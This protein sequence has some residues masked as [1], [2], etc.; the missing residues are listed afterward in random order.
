MAKHVGMPSGCSIQSLKWIP[1][2]SNL[3]ASFANCASPFTS[4]TTY[5]LG[6][7]KPKIIMI[8]LE[9]KRSNLWN[10]F[11]CH[12]LV[13]CIAFDNRLNISLTHTFCKVIDNM[14]S[15]PSPENWRPRFLD[16]L[17]CDNGR[18]IANC[19]FIA[20]SQRIVASMYTHFSGDE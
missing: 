18:P 5:T 20:E 1:P 11:L 15:S 9:D 16:I 2:S 17:N 10:V 4:R 12:P 3:A 8:Y 14:Q 6:K 13:T 7:K 19:H